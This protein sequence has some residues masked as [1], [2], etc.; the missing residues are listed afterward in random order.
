MGLVYSDYSAEVH[1]VG[2]FDARSLA[3]KERD[4]MAFVN[5]TKLLKAQSQQHQPSTHHSIHATM[6]MSTFLLFD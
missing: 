5:H 3:S 1:S 2:G 6:I 4:V